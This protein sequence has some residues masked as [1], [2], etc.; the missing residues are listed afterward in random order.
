MTTIAKT[1]TKSLKLA[2]IAARICAHLKRFELD[3]K[4]NRYPDKARENLNPY[5]MPVA[6]ASGRFVYVTYISYQGQSHLVRA[7]AEAYL[8]WLDAGSQ[9]VDEV[10]YTGNFWRILCQVKCERCGR[11]CLGYGCY[12]QS[13][14]ERG[15]E[16]ADA[17]P[18]R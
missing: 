10:G 15:E 6:G 2:D 16:H 4:I 13:D 5:Y 9:C 17:S 7:E 8:A 1:A 11:E 3:P 12:W 18:P 14:G